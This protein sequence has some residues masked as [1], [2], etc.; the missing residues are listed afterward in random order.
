MMRCACPPEKIMVVSAT[1]VNIFIGIAS[2]SAA[3]AAFS[4][5]R[6]AASRS[7]SRAT[8]AMFSST[9]PGRNAPFCMTTPTCHR[10]EC[11]LIAARS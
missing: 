3:T 4:A 8:P 7:T 2:M 9:V 10:T 5:A 11:R 6:H 1:D